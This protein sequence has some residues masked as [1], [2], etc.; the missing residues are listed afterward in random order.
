MFQGGTESS[1]TNGEIIL[2]YFNLIGLNATTIGN[3]EYDESRDSIQ[4]K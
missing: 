4:G 2:D 3:H 1:L